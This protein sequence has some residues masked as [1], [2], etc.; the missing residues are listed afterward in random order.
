MGDDMQ[1]WAEGGGTP[2]VLPN[3]EIRLFAST[4]YHDWE[5]GCE[6]WSQCFWINTLF[7]VAAGPVEVDMPAPL[8]FSDYW[9]GIDSGME[10]I[11]A[12]EAERAGE[13]RPSA[14]SQL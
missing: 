14:Y 5:N 7:G 10:A 3:S 9:Q 12:A 6:D 13:E 2:M 8:M 11:L 1:F 4:G